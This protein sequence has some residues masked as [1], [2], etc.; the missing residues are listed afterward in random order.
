[1]CVPR[2]E[3][4]AGAAAPPEVRSCRNCAIRPGEASSWRAGGGLRGLVVLAGRAGVRDQPL[5]LRLP[6]PAEFLRPRA[7]VDPAEERGQVIGVAGQGV[8]RRLREVGITTQ[9]APGYA[10]AHEHVLTE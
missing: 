5:L 9:P 10:Y 3:L 1:M 8:D 4:I 6:E 2:R 7:A